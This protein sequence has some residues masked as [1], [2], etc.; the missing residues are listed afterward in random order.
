MQYIGAQRCQALLH[1]FLPLPLITT[2]KGL[3]FAGVSV[4]ILRAEFRSLRR[5]EKFLQHLLNEEV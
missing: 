5:E 3:A 1:L 4:G 2:F